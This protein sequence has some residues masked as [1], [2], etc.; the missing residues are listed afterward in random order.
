VQLVKA[1]GVEVLCAA[2]VKIMKVIKIPMYEAGSQKRENNHLPTR[3][4]GYQSHDSWYID[5]IKVLVGKVGTLHPIEKSIAF[6]HIHHV[7]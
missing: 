3:N 2:F 6:V 4:V 1:I 7:I 5:L